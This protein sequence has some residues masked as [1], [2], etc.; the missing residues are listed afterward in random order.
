MYCTESMAQ[1]S[2]QVSFT[3][4]I[5]S[6]STYDANLKRVSEDST[7]NLWVFSPGTPV[8][9]TT[10]VDKRELTNGAVVSKHNSKEV[11]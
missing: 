10:K 8:S 6:W 2:D 7:K 3:S 4:Q 5:E 11:T 1:L 9:S